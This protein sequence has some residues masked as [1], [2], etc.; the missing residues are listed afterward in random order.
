[1]SYR[2]TSQVNKLNK[3]EGAGKYGSRIVEK[4]SA[5]KGARLKALMQKKQM[6]K[7]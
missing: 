6:L 7:D 3:A 1:M 5:G 2:A 4:I